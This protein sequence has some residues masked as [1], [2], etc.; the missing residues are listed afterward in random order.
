MSDGRGTVEQ[1]YDFADRVAG[2]DFCAV[3]DHAFEMTDEMWQHSKRATNAAYEPG[4]F[5]TF[6]AYEWSG[7]T[8][9][10]G[11]HNCYFLDDDPPIYRST[12]YYSP[13]NLQMYH[14]PT[15]KLRHV[16]D[17]FSELRQRITEKNLLCIPHFGGRPGN[18]QWHDAHVQRLIEIFSEHRRSQDW[19]STF[20]AEGHRL[21]IIASSDDHFGNPGYGFLKPTFNWD[22][23]E[24]GMGLVAVYAAERSR[25]S[26]FRALY[27][28]H[29]Y[30]TS[31]DRII[32]E[33]Q[34]DQHP[35]GGEYQSETPPSLEMRAVGTDLVTRVEFFKNGQLAHVITPNRQTVHTTWRD[36]EFDAHHMNYYFV[37]VVQA[38]NEEAICS[39]VWV[40]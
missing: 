30:A 26:V 40:E 38:N 29:V 36:P 33:F 17:L 1:Y 7:V 32:L 19:A 28:R 11:D 20:L 14:G 12:S 39:P 6:Q 18:P 3:S 21:G 9:L 24:I 37:R 10:G 5:V 35:P 23:Q 25:E 8:P 13:D 34:A 27:D 31:G 4:R 15:P 22:Q 16:T 2:L